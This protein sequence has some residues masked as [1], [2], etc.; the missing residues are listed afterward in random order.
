[1]R[2]LV[3]FYIK[4]VRTN[5]SMGARTWKIYIHQIAMDIEQIKTGE[6]RLYELAVGG[7]AV[8]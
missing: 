1:M 5:T 2:Y 4:S 8:G 6:T 3:A 7:N